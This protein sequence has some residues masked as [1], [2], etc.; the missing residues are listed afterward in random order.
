MDIGTVA[1]Y[2]FAGASLLYVLH[3][4][5]YLVGAN[6]YD[7]WQLRRKRM[8]SHR[9]H[10][11]TP[12]VTVLIAAR[13][14]ELVIERCLR[15]VQQSTYQYLQVIVIDDGS[16]DLTNMIVRQYIRKH[17]GMNIRVIRRRRNGGKGRALNYAL[18]HYAEG[19]LVMT[20]DADSIISKDAISNALSYFH[21]P[22]VVGV[23][24]NVQII[25]EFT[26]L[27]VLQRFEHMIG[28]RAKK[29]YSLTNCEFVI[30]GVAS[31][32]RMSTLRSV[33]FYSVDTVTEDIGLSMK[34][35]SHGNRNRK[36]VYAADVAARTEGVDSFRALLKQRYRW[37]Y[38]SLQNLIKYHHIIGSTDMK[39]TAMFA[40]Y[41]MPMA[42]ISEFILL[43]APLLWGYALYI[44]FSERSLSLFAGAYMTITAY[45]LIALW[46]DENTRLKDRFLLSLYAPITYFIFY[47]MDIVQIVAVLRCIGEARQLLAQKEGDSVW[48]SPPRIGQD[49]SLE[50]S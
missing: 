29:T 11:F 36:I 32:Y 25:D 10:S 20:L 22:H 24:A 15:S 31:T 39:F 27:G 41:R 43:A 49:V 38:G 5:F 37:K 3:F 26:I 8:L 34:I 16:T 1:F 23:A 46:F 2:I 33:G 12:L 21:D 28:Y 7:I 40:L 17:P 13:N 35:I 48:Q 9:K 14:E 45:L 4:G 50:Q 47:I 42:V 19:E 44:T 30:G 6:A 18:K